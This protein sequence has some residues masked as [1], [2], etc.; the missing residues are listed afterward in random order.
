MH[1][2]PNY[3]AYAGPPAYNTNCS[4]YYRL[5][6][7]L[8]PK[9]QQYL[10]D[11]NMNARANHLNRLQ[12]GLMQESLKRE[13]LTNKYKAIARSIFGT[14]C[15]LVT[16]DIS[17]AATSAIQLPIAFVTV[18]ICAVLTGITMGFRASSRVLQNKINKHMKIG[19]LA[20]ATLNVTTDKV[21][22][23]IEDNTITPEEFKDI[24]D[25][26]EKFEEMKR[27]IQAEYSSKKDQAQLMEAEKE[28]LRNEG[29]LKVKRDLTLRMKKM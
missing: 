15:V 7:N 17:L 29:A 27:K 24:T 16:T 21:V 9:D 8:D 10:A 22:K 18:P 23:A 3:S 13:K 19:L 14:E 6:Q 12:D 26:F 1:D 5:T 4:P 28:R 25:E 11:M 2:D 20:K